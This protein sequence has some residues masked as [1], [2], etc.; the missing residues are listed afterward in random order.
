MVFFKAI[1]SEYASGTNDELSLK[2]WDELSEIALDRFFHQCLKPFEDLRNIGVESQ[3]RLCTIVDF[4][5]HCC[6]SEKLCNILQKSMLQDNSNIIQI[7]VY[8]VK[9]CNNESDSSRYGNDDSTSMFYGLQ[10]GAA[11]I[12]GQLCTYTDHSDQPH[13]TLPKMK[14]TLCR[15]L[16]RFES[17]TLSSEGVHVGEKTK[18]GV[19]EFAVN[20]SS[21][22][23]LTRRALNFQ[24]ILLSFGS[25]SGSCMTSTI[26][27]SSCKKASLLN[28]SSEHFTRYQ[29]QL[30]RLT[31]QCVIITRE[32]D[33]LEQELMNKDAFFKQQVDRAKL[34][35][36]VDAL[37]HAENL[38]EE[39]GALHNKCMHFE[40]ELSNASLEIKRLTYEGVQRENALNAEVDECNR[41]IRQLEDQ[42]KKAQNKII[43]KNEE[44]ERR[45]ERLAQADIA[46]KEKQEKLDKETKDKLSLSKNH[47]ELKNSHINVKEK[48]EDALSKLISFANIYVALEKNSDGERKELEQMTEDAQTKESEVRAKYQRLKEMYRGAEDKIRNLSL[49]LEKAKSSASHASKRRIDSNT[50]NR[51]QPMGTLA[52]M[53]SLHDNSTRTEG[54]EQNVKDYSVSRSYKSSHR[55]KSKKKNSSSYRIVK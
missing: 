46:L 26:F 1:L 21:S 49:K 8:I 27:G 40:E 5:S 7:L 39:K 53:N 25:N 18:D 6:R 4:M 3:L 22:R 32:R 9:Q 10:L 34:Q 2:S 43:A 33:T 24:S 23:D 48:L 16:K 19:I 13:E 17:N 42:L 47:N 35:S 15:I 41:K 45:E 37:E 30:E 52:F 44:I 55:S 11:W 51:R 14:S 36:K 20:Q 28:Q 12:L 54:R 38:L 29:E 50:S 31:E